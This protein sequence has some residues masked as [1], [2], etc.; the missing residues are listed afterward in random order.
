MHSTKATGRAAVLV[1]CVLVRLWE[2]PADYV[3]DHLRIIRPVA[4]ETAEQENVVRQY[5]NSVAGNF[6]GYYSN[7]QTKWSSMTAF[8]GQETIDQSFV[9]QPI[10]E[11]F[12]QRIQE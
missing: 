6:G 1:A 5:H 4:I 2:A 9:D 10:N 11:L 7:K 12:Q 8:L 3:I